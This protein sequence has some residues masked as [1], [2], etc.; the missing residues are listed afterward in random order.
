MISLSPKKI[1]ITIEIFFFILIVFLPVFTYAQAT[2]PPVTSPPAGTGIT[3][4]CKE[5]VNGETVYGNCKFNDLITATIK[6]VKFGVTI[7]LMLSVVVIAFAGSKYMIS[8]DK[9][10]ERQKANEMLRKVAIGIVFILAAWLIVTLIA[11]SLLTPGVLELVPLGGST[12]TA[13]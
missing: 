9:P 10:G 7:T 11:N 2:Q 5:T 12:Q 1:G 4:E 8:G 3:Y 13:P 6:L